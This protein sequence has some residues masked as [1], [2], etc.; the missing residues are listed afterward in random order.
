M[1]ESV[2]TGQ[3]RLHSEIT[4]LHI[5]KLVAGGDGLAFLGG[6]AVFIPLTL[7]DE[8]IVARIVLERR[9]YLRAELVSVV[10]ASPDR[11]E[12]S[13]PLFGRCGGCNL[14]HCSPDAQRR[15]KAGIVRELF[16]RTSGV[17]FDA[18]PAGIAVEAGAAYGYRNR[19]QLHFDAE[20]RLGLSRRE[21]NEVLAIPGCPVAVAGLDEWIGERSYSTGL[22]GEMAPYLGN[23]DRFVAFG[24]GKKVWIEG[25]HARATVEIGGQPISFPLGSFFQSNLELLER[26]VPAVVEGFEGGRAADL[27]AGVGLFGRFLAEKGSRVTLVEENA[28]ALALAR[29][30]A[31]GPAHEYVHQSVDAWCRGPAARAD[32][33]FLVVDPPRTGLSPGL[34]AWIVERKPPLVSYVSCDP[35]TLARDAKALLS[36]GYRLESLRLFDFYPQTGHIEALARFAWDGGGK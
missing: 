7:P 6:R 3:P 22:R 14:Q 2:E 12:P 20:G 15:L 35:V 5:D 10:T 8:D 28:E 1:G 9:D 30:N 19:M 27:Y 25:Q 18:G 26:L 16:S 31:K 4:K 34:A 29:V 21:S 36:G 23:R 32:F 24:S 13:C 33:D 11:V 17:D